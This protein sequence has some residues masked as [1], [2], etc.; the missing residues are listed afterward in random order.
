MTHDY[1]GKTDLAENADTKFGMC[2]NI[3]EKSVNHQTNCT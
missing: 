1:D 3:S 2:Q